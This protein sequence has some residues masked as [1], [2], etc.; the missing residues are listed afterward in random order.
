MAR[1]AIYDLPGPDTLTARRIVELTAGVLGQAPPRVI[2]VP[3]LS[4]WLSS[5]WVRLV[6]R[7][8]WAVARELVLGLTHDLLARDE[9]YWGEI[10]HQR[11][12]GFEEAARRALAEER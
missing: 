5:H 7:A 2:E 1:G 10:G 6:T 11:R 9:R 4:P 8:D 12:L 3:F